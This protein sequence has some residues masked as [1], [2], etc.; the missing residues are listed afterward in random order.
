[1]SGGGA[2]K[3]FCNL[4]NEISRYEGVNVSLLL[5]ANVGPNI[6]HI[7]KKVDIFYLTSNPSSIKIALSSIKMWNILKK[8]NPDCL[9]ST[10]EISNSLNVTIGALYKKIYNRELF[11]VTRE[12]NTLTD[13]NNQLQ[14]RARSSFVFDRIYTKFVSNAD[15]VIANS[16]DT[17]NDICKF[18]SVKKEKVRVIDNPV[19]FG[20]PLKDKEVLPPLNENKNSHFRLVSVGRLTYQ[21]NHLF[22]LSVAKYLKERGYDF[23]LDIYGE[24]EEEDALMEYISQNGLHNYVS[25]KGYATNVL[26]VLS[27]YDLFILSSR[28][29]GFGNVIVESLSR[30]LPVLSSD[31]PGGP[32]AIL[33]DNKLGRLSTLCV[34]NYV[35]LIVELIESDTHTK[36]LFRVNYANKYH[37]KHIAKKYFDV[38][39]NRGDASNEDF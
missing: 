21:K 22:T 19:L 10:L 8:I 14:K 4:V 37:S 33:T 27:N 3:V 30:G 34:Q 5:C 9:F 26:N 1:M 16:V 17:K 7:D 38:L 39:S 2:E 28:W 6:K 11:I 31:C 36:R 24:G 35:N 29:E 23:L 20:N 15:F 25:L 32:S 18:R 13:V 12:A